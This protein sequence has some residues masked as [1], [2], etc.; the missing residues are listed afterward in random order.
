MSNDP[1]YPVQAAATTFRI[2]E[3][4]HELNG[5]GVSELAAELEM[6]KSTVHDHLQTLTEAEYLVNEDGTY[7]VGTRFLELGGFARSQMKLY[8]I[9]SPEIK[10]LAEEQVN[11][12][13]S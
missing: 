7:R 10:E 11:T 5:A 3:T 6:P 12:R 4:L 8:Q 1:R 9:A 2:I 13:I